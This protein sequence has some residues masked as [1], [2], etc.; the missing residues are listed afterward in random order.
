MPFQS[1]YPLI[2]STGI[3][4]AAIGVTAFDSNPAPGI[5][6]KLGLALTGGIVMFIGIYLWSLEGAEGYHLHLDAD[7][8]HERPDAPSCPP[9][10]LTDSTFLHEQPRGHRPPSITI[11]ITRRRPAFRTRSSSCGRFWPR[12]ACSSAR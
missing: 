10:A 5:H 2:A 6:W 8:G 1:I 9:E 3:L 12:T 7:E 4:I 11:T